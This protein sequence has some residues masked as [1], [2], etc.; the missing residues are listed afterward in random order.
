MGQKLETAPAGKTSHPGAVSAPTCGVQLCLCSWAGLEVSQII[1]EYCV[2]TGSSAL[3]AHV[4]SHVGFRKRHRPLERRSFWQPFASTKPAWGGQGSHVPSKRKQ[5]TRELGGEWEAHR[6]GGKGTSL[7]E[8]VRQVRWRQ[9]C[10]KKT[11]GRRIYSEIR[12]SL[13]S[14]QADL[15]AGWVSLLCYANFLQ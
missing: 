1:N 5:G 3:Y 2:P 9:R 14:R 12:D 11:P 6:A 7:Q 13:I 4:N 15:P 10:L 8:G